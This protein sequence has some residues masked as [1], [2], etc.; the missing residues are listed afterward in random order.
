MVDC[1]QTKSW[2]LIVSTNL[3]AL[4]IA[5]KH[6]VMCTGVYNQDISSFGAGSQDFTASLLLMEASIEQLSRGHA[7]DERLW[8]AA[9]S[10]YS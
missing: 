5:V 2:Q 1:F 6:T 9:T 4:F 8:W 3:I 7:S 10:A